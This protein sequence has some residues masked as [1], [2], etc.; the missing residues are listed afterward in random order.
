MD[1]G[2]TFVIAGAADEAVA[3]EVAGEVATQVELMSA[4]AE[5]DDMAEGNMAD[6][7][8]PVTE[9]L[10]A[11]LNLELNGDTVVAGVIPLKTL[12]DVD[13]FFSKIGFVI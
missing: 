2:D 10:A 4:P 7:R 1:E 9:E 12:A 6:G 3:K 13:V 11:E 5:T 8:L